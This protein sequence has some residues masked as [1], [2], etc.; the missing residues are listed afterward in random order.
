M[1]GPIRKCSACDTIFTQPNVRYFLGEAIPICPNRFCAAEE[2]D[3]DFFS[4]ADFFDQFYGIIAESF[5]QV[6]RSLWREI[7]EANMQPFNP[8]YRLL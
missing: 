4:D 1:I 3:W 5:N 8:L 7:A 2:L 6:T